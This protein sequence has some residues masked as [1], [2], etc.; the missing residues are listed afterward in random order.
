MLP[1]RIV[2]IPFTYL[3]EDANACCL[4]L[5]IWTSKT[6]EALIPQLDLTQTGHPH[7]QACSMEYVSSLPFLCQI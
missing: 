3:Q 2:F 7:S 5:V 1:L 6:I 4:R